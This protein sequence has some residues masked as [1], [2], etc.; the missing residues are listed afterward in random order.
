ML[1]ITFL[2]VMDQKQWPKHGQQS[3]IQSATSN[4]IKT[5]NTI[6]LQ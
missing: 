6:G 4:W 3:N 5:T 1:I 2:N